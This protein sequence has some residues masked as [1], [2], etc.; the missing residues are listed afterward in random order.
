MFNQ[1]RAVFI[2]WAKTMP[3]T[4]GIAERL[5]ARDFYIERMKGAPRIFVPLRYLLQSLDT[6]AV[7]WR[8]RPELIVVSNPPIVLPLIAYAAARML[9]AQLVIDSHT[10]AFDGKW[11]YFLSAH[12]FLSR[13]AAGT[14]VTNEPLRQMVQSWGAPAMVLED[15]VPDLPVPSDDRFKVVVVSSF[16]Q[17][18]PLEAV[19]AAAKTLPEYRFFV[20]GRAPKQMAPILAAAP[21]NVTFTGFVPRS[22][23]VSL[24]HRADAVMVLVKRDLT[25]LC[26]AYEAV[27]VEKPLITSDWPVLKNYFS[28]G[29][30]YVDN[31][32][33]SIRNAVLEAD[34]S[35]DRLRSEMRGLKRSLGR[36]W[37]D[38][39]ATVCAHIEEALGR[40]G[41]P[42]CAAGKPGGRAEPPLQD[43]PAS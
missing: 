25:L 34:K 36:K 12:R 29:A 21:R 22:D 27:A 39:F 30:L 14:I 41:M 20:T 31:S 37:D 8:E 4:K 38:H 11:K 3:R 35:A 33:E 28:A 26:G 2:S 5:G 19:L 18:E 17:D 23:Y 7:L 42:S 43:R 24:L 10:G 9:N 40:E 32:P 13:R 16:A 1:A 15:R 6:L